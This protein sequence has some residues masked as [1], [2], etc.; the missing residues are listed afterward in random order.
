IASHRANVLVDLAALHNATD[1]VC[2]TARTHPFL[3]AEVDALTRALA[4]LDRPWTGGPY[5]EPARQALAQNAERAG[6]RVAEPN[7]PA[8]T[9][10]PRDATLVVTHGE[11][12][13]GNLITTPSGLRWIDWD[14]AALARP[15]RDLWMLATG[16]P[17]EF[18]TYE[19]R[20]G[21]TI[22]RNAI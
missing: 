13:P 18:A 10:D 11:P 14:T 19:Q 21:N 8:A 15:E 20:T 1:V 6:A 22:D 16:T 9:V 17:D 5:S 3:I 4:E 7:A 2:D 12:H